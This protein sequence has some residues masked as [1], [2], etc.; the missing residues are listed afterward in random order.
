LLETLSGRLA[1]KSA[2]QE[3]SIWQMGFAAWKIT[4]GRGARAAAPD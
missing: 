3:F 2:R 4:F 1:A